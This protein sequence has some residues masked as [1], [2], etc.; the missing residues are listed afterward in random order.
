MDDGFTWNEKVKIKN[1]MDDL[2]FLSWR[3]ETRKRLSTT[4]TYS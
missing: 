1:Q 2:E 3:F 4:F